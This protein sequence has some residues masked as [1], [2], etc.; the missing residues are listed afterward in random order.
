MGFSVCNNNT[1]FVNNGN[2]SR[3]NLLGETKVDVGVKD[4]SNNNTERK[5]EYESNINNDNDSS[6]SERVSKEEEDNNVNN[7]VHNN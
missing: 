2:V 1:T 4:N 3:V 7:V 5:D 6:N